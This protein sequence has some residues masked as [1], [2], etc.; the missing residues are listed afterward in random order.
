MT[1]PLRSAPLKVGFVGCGGVAQVVHLPIL[2]Q[3]EEVELVALCDVDL[4]KATVLGDKFGVPHCYGD[5][6]EMVTR[7]QLDL[8]FVLTPNNLRMPISM[9]VLRHNAHLFLE[10]PAGLNQAE[11]ARIATEAR[12]RNLHVMVGMQNRFRS[13]VRSIKTFLDAQEVG[14]VF[15]GRSEWLQSKFPVQKQPWVFK[16]KIAGGGVVMDLGLPLIDMVWWL[17]GKPAVRSVRAYQHP[18]KKDLEVEDFCVFTLEFDNHFTLLAEVSW[19]FPTGRD[20][21][22]VELVGSAGTCKLNPLRIQKLWRGQL[23]NITPELRENSTTIF[24][25]SY[26]NEIRHYVNFLL[27]K[28]S[29]LESSIEDAVHVMGMVDMIYRSLATGKEVRAEHAVE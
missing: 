24:R 10:K 15:Y 8:V 11:V 26:E 22:S 3:V 14:E 1:A 13:D 20:S 23:L 27:G 18:I 5:V 7:H 21:L 19:D 17:I 12:Q 2:S 28:V 6:E 4:R 29:N 16:K 25:K 9:M